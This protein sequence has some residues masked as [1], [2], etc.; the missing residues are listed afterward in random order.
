MWRS[1]GQKMKK[2]DLRNLCAHI[3]IGEMDVRNRLVMPAMGSGLANEEGTP[4]DRMIH[5]YQRRAKGGAGLII[6]ELTAV[7]ALGML[8]L[9]A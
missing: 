3:R 4:S 8:A 6:V 7:H 1:E 5:Y 2:T 9:I